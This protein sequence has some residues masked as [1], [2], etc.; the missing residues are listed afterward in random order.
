M[1]KAELRGRLGDARRLVRIERARQAGLDVAE[2]A[3]ARAGVA[4][5][6]EGGV[7]LLPALADIGAAGL[8]ADG[9]QA[10]RAHDPLRLRIALR[11]RRLDADPVG[12]AQRGVSGPMRLLGM[13]RARPAGGVEND[14]H[15]SLFRPLT[16]AAPICAARWLDR[17]HRRRG[18]PT[19]PAAAAAAPSAGSG[20][21]CARAASRRARQVPDLAEVDAELEQAMLVQ[22]QRRA[23]IACSSHGRDGMG[24]D[25]VVVG[26]QRD[27]PAVGDPLQQPLVAA[28]EHRRRRR[29]RPSRRACFHLEHHVGRSR[30]GGRPCRPARP[31]PC[32]PPGRIS[33]S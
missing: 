25:G 14:G 17:R 12:L 28:V 29:A 15:G 32:P 22:R 18:E 1:R 6:H 19:R 21:A 16:Y 8:L 11:D 20:C 24:L 10:V 2:G 4:H 23:V 30:C 5:D 9:V 13:A 33:S 26:D 3:G 27:Q 7:L 31:R